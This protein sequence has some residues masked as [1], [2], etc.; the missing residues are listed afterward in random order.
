MVATEGC[1]ML[2]HYK[3]LNEGTTS[4]ELEAFVH[5]Y[6][7]IEHNTVDFPNTLVI[8]PTLGSTNRPHRLDVLVK[9]AVRRQPVVPSLLKLSA[10]FVAAHREPALLR[11]V[12]PTELQL[13]VHDSWSAAQAPAGTSSWPSLL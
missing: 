4:H 13:L 5:R 6:E 9:A 10:R 3:V 2:G 7:S 12:L 11:G 8:T 1:R